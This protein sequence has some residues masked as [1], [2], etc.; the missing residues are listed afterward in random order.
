M[1]ADAVSANASPHH[2][3]SLWCIH[4]DRYSPW[5]PKRPDKSGIEER[6][7]YRGELLFERPV[8]FVVPEAPLAI[9]GWLD[10]TDK[11]TNVYIDVR[12]RLPRTQSEHNLRCPKS[13]DCG[14]IQTE[15][16][17]TE[18][19]EPSSKERTSLVGKTLG[20]YK[21]VKQLGSG[22]MGAVYEGLQE[23]IGQRVAV[24][25]MHAELSRES[26]FTQRFFAEARAVSKVKHPGLIQI[27]LFEQLPDGTLYL[28]M[29]LLQ[30]E[31]LWDRMK[32]FR[33][34]KEGGAFPL[35]DAVRITRQIASA[36][37]A[38][39]QNNII[40]R[41]LK[42]ENVFLVPDPDT[43]SG[44]RAKILDFGIAKDAAS[45][46][47]GH[48][49]TTGLS[50]GTPG[51]MSPEQCAGSAKLTD[52]SDVY[53]L[54][55]IFYEL[56]SG[57]PPLEAD[58]TMALMRQHITKDPNP[59]PS[60]LPVEISQLATQMLAKDAEPRPSMQQVVER[61][62]AF[63]SGK[64]SALP[65]VTSNATLQR[66]YVLGASVVLGAITLSVLIWLLVRPQPAG[67]KDPSH[68][69]SSQA[70]KGT[71]ADTKS[72]AVSVPADKSKVTAAQTAASKGE[73]TTTPPKEEQ[74]RSVK[75]TKKGS[76][77]LF[78]DRTRKS[79]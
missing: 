37:A 78:P 33:D 28:V 39:H 77:S 44:E 48:R 76:A 26:K 65:S 68:K 41:D 1:S 19:A 17:M 31:L 57:K 18:S 72:E 64:V 40:H 36:F 24:K 38:V 3:A 52:R 34:R 62:D 30:G 47:G 54:G 29:E 46:A 20:R 23:D 67:T 7:S 22:G 4:C 8:V 32:R 2:R 14:T 49:T 43:P 25:V 73:T 12:T 50:I 70:A 74:P 66:R 45:E 21:I 15:P 16:Q 75:K 71:S 10:R 53:A 27:Y 35:A 9:A 59:L 61:L 55:V 5:F 60:S 79:K 51:Y 56:L 42:P 13:A 58:T 63:S 69:T 11:W 6:T